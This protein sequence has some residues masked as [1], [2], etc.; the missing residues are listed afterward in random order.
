MQDV[1]RQV[2]ASASGT[3][4]TP[5]IALV[6]PH[7]A[8]VVDIV[9]A[10]TSVTGV[11]VATVV[12]CV[13]VP[14]ATVDIRRTEWLPALK[15]YVSDP[16]VCMLLCFHSQRFAL[17]VQCYRG[18]SQHIL[19]TG[20]DKSSPEWISHCRSMLHALNPEAVFARVHGGGGRP[21][22]ISHDVLT[23]IATSTNF[24]SDRLAQLR[25]LSL[26]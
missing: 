22:S 11:S 24:A 13:H 12:M 6:S 9:S 18:Y 20:C 8:A 10:V 4:T 19:L 7:N 17:S 15:T 25:Q 23:S 5:R 21:L 16:S 2:R 26:R 1:A 14:T 3:G